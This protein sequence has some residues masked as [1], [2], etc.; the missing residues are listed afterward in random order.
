MYLKYERVCKKV[1]FASLKT[2]EYVHQRLSRLQHNPHRPDAVWVT[3]GGL[4][5]DIVISSGTLARLLI[6]DHSPPRVSLHVAF[7]GIVV[8]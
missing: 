4:G 3:F 2:V 5:F 8:G 7:I 6:N 1:S